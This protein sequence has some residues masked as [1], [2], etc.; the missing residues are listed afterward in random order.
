[1]LRHD[2]RLY[3]CWLTGPTRVQVVS[4]RVND[5]AIAMAYVMVRRVSLLRFLRSIRRL[6]LLDTTPP[7]ALALLIGK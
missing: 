3:V 1:M 6:V 2:L 4:W 5:A 7:H